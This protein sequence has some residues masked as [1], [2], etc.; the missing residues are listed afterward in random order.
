MF[1]PKVSIALSAAEAGIA[2][3]ALQIERGDHLSFWKNLPPCV[4]LFS[5]CFAA[6]PWLGARW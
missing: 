1:V 5:H 6:C 3:F 2:K 4:E